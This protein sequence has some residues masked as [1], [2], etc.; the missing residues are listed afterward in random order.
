MKIILKSLMKS[1]LFVLKNIL[2]LGTFYERFLKQNRNDI[3][4][5]EKEKTI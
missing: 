4:A 2:I 1:T 3:I 5:T